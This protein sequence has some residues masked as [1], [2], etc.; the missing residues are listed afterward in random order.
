MPRQ[1]ASSTN[2]VQRNEVPELGSNNAP[3]ILSAADVEALPTNVYDDKAHGTAS[4]NHIF[5]AP[6]TPTNGL[7]L[8]LARF[9]PHAPSQKSFLAAHRHKQAEFYYLLKGQCVVTIEGMEHACQPGHVLFIPGDAEHGVRNTSTTEEVVFLW[10]FAADGFDQILYRF[11]KEQDLR[12]DVGKN[13]QGA[14]VKA[15]L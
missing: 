4:W 9:P 7:T 1:T 2:D 3:V 15:R 13:K 10:G 8:G 12:G 6:D 5:N 11:S 14:L